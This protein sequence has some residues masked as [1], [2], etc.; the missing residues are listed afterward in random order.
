[1]PPKVI[2]VIDGNLMAHKSLHVL[3]DLSLKD[4]TPVGVIYGVL[5]QLCTINSKIDPDE[6][7]ITWD[8]GSQRRKKMYSEYKANRTITDGMFHQQLLILNQILYDIGLSQIMVPGEEADDIIGS[9]C[10][11]NKDCK[12]VIVT[13]DHDF[14]QLI[15]EDV[16]VYSYS[17]LNSKMSTIDTVT[18]EYGVGP[19]RLTD[20]FALT[21]DSSDN[22]KGLDGIG[23]KTSSKIIQKYINLDNLLE[24]DKIEF[25]EH[26]NKSVMEN[27]DMLRLNKILVTINKD[28]EYNLKRGNKNLDLVKVM[29]KDFLDFNYFLNHWHE[30]ENLSKKGGA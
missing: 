27:K 4:G 1:V 13:S 25:S 7:I 2:C 16:Y 26:I 21:G 10:N 3:K 14:F 20:L 9:Y 19:D 8:G 6:I 30:I 28:I 12:I 18:E 29:F 23:I 17:G 5:K 22:I 15:N 11:N 24:Q